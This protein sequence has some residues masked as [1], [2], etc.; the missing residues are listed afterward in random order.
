MSLAWPL[1]DLLS[2][3]TLYTCFKYAAGFGLAGST[4]AA[5][6]LYLYQ[7][8]LIYPSY[9]PEGSRKIV[10]TPKDVALPYED[11]KL[12]T[13]DGVKIRAYVIPARRKQISTE[14]LKMASPSARK[15]IA[16]KEVADWTEE[17]GQDEA[18]EYAK[19]R[20]TIILFHANAGNVGHRVP[21]ARKFNADYKC[22][23][24]MLSYRG[25]G[26]SEGSAS[27]MGIRK[28]VDAAFD[29]I[30]AHPILGST[31]LVAYG[32]SIGGAVCLYTGYKY[33]DLLSGIIIENTFLSL[34]NLVPLVLP[35]LPKFLLPLL[36]TEQWDATLSLPHIPPSLPMLFL[37][38]KRDALVPPAQ[39]QELYRIRGDGKKR[40]KELDGEHN[41]TYL[42]K[43]YWEEVGDWL[44]EEVETP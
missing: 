10:P 7:C 23:V 12:T 43:G 44:H 24:F 3:D 19:S 33:S 25:Y 18:I 1:G 26:L 5:T 9:V 2:T 8:K 38:G 35:Q 22:N 21:I 15:E 28:D 40:W 29:Y 37:S 31:K 4:I 41:D 36:L 42:A 39:M 32:Q 11:V 13:S 17:M 30:R 27:E 14:D 20:P 6:G 34:P 16:E